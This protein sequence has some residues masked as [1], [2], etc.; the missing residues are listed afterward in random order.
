MRRQPVGRRGTNMDASVALE[1]GFYDHAHLTNTMRRRLGMTP[2]E[3]RSSRQ[4]QK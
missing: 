4:A 3:L 2:S 1:N